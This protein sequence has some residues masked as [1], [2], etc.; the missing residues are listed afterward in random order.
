MWFLA[1]GYATAATCPEKFALL[2]PLL[3]TPTETRIASGAPGPRHW[4]RR[5][6]D[7]IEVTLDDQRHDFAAVWTKTPYRELFS[8]SGVY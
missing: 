6:D 5:A 7:N 3:D 1:C 4:Q 8:P 2:G